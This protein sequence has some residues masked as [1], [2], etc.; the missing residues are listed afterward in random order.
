MAKSKRTQLTKDEKREI[1]RRVFVKGQSI[2]R[3]AKA[4][5]RS[6]GTI[7][8]LIKKWETEETLKRKTAMTDEEKESVVALVRR[9]PSIS[10]ARVCTKLDL[11]VSINTVSRYLDRRGFVRTGPKSA[12]VRLEM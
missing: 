2:T 3:V 5:Q 8:Y 1:V 7:S 10:L 9:K 6:R 11:S 4:M 12:P